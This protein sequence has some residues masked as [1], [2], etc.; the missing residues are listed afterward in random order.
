MPSKAVSA[1]KRVTDSSA[2][3]AGA[4]G[5]PGVRDM[6]PAFRLAGYGGYGG[7]GCSRRAARSGSR[8]GRGRGWP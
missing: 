6:V 7:R 1:L 2:E 4:G 5:L 8:R 3:L